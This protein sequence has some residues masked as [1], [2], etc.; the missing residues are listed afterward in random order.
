MF[1]NN[2]IILFFIA[3]L[4]LCSCAK[5]GPNGATGPTGPS[6]PAYTGYLDGH[7]T[8]YDE[9]GSIILTGLH[10]VQ[11][12]LTNNTP[13]YADSFGY[14]IFSNVT[15]GVYALFAYDSGF[16]TTRI[17]NISFINDTLNQDIQLSAIPSYYPTSLTYDTIANAVNIGFNSDTRNR[18][19]IVFVNNAPTVNG[20]DTA[21]LLAYRT[22]AI[23]GQT[24]IS[25]S[26]PFQDLVNAGFAAG[27]PVYF[28]AYGEAFNDA[29]VYKDLKTGKNIWNAISDSSI[30]ISGIVP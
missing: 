5:E 16:G 11:I 24:N 29:S 22:Q 6:G 13:A 23:S 26:I 27:E 3:S 4:L 28:R 18:E 7:V 9:Y 12:S 19:F 20:S 15:T 2:L 14:Y 17:N 21:Y 8:L 10:K 25:L 1:R 30:L